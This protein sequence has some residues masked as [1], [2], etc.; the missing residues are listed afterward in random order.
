[1]TY[2]D[3]NHLIHWILIRRGLTPHGPVNGDFTSFYPTENVGQFALS[4]PAWDE[5]CYFMKW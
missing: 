4:Y 2:D 5:D 3:L 1:M